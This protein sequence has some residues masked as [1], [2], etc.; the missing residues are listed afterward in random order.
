[1]VRLSHSAREKYEQCNYKYYLHYV[2]K[3]R[4]SLQSSAL[5][6]G[7][8]LDLSLNSLLEG[9]EDYH[10]VFDHEWDKYREVNDSIQYYKS[11]LDLKLLTEEE[12]SMPV[13]MQNFLS[14]RKKGHKL[15]DAYKKEI[16][17]RIKKVISIQ[18]EITIVG[19]DE[20]GKETSDSIYG[21][22]D[23][24][25]SIEDGDGNVR[26]ALLDNKTTS[27][28]YA[29]DSVQKKDQLALY[30]SGYPD[31]EYFGYLTMN[32]KNYKTQ[33]I[34]DT[35][36]EDKKNEVL[37]KF[38]TTLDSINKNNFEKNTKSCY[39]FGRQCEFYTHCHRGFFSKDIYQEKR[40]G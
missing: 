5:C 28:P 1:M 35:I 37:Q 17:P 10:L 18:E 8:A 4:S 38:V 19:Y 11:D 9:K 36:S 26:H 6:F 33:V 22:L 24:I 30:A 13:Q 21:K 29:K 3:Y 31:I 23:L 34:I 14:L 25:A 15:L 7:N 27:E 32:K 40:E 12:R 39:A 16:F 20:D 2:M